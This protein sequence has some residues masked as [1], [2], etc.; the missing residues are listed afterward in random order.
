MDLLIPGQVLFQDSEG[1]GLMDGNF[2][3]II[4]PVFSELG[5]LDPVSK[6]AKAVYGKGKEKIEGY[7]DDKGVFVIVKGKPSEW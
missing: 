2:N 6:L 4:P 1:R 5:F 7:V 3:V